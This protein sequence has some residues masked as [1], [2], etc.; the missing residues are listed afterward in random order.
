MLKDNGCNANMKFFTR[1]G[2]IKLFFRCILL[3]LIGSV[4][5]CAHMADTDTPPAEVDNS[6]MATGVLVGGVAGAAVGAVSGGGV[7]IPVAAAMGGIV[8]GAVASAMLENESPTDQLI[9]QLARD[10]VQ[11]IRIGEDYM[12]VLPSTSYFYP[13][14]SHLNANMYP[15][16]KDVAKFINLYD[17]ETIKVAGY[18]NNSGD[19]ARNVALSRQQAQYIQE[20]LWRDGVRPA[21][22]YAIGY[23]S[24]YPIAHNETKEGQLVN[25]RVQITFRR[26][27]PQS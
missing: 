20:E 13:N 22:M 24:Q 18:T 17:T 25:N 7:A 21:F 2:H 23:G 8:G 3:F 6:K 27:T 4:L 26:L 12:I 10:H 16:L 19:E 11:V 14:S 9:S 5:G 15:A 1:D